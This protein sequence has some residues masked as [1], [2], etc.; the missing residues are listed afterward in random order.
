MSKVQVTALVMFVIQVIEY[1]ELNGA[2]TDEFQ[3]V[4][5]KKW[6]TAH[7]LRPAATPLRPAMGLSDNISCADALRPAT[8][9]FRPATMHYGPQHLS[10]RPATRQPNL[11]RSRLTVA[12]SLRPAKDHVP[13]RNQVGQ[14]PF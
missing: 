11:L 1:S 13:V 7:S 12:H 3:L 14:S 4:K 8:I 5:T 10:F 9:S 6:N 2:R